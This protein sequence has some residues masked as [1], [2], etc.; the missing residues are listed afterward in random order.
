MQDPYLRT[1]AMPVQVEPQAERSKPAVL[2]EALSVLSMAIAVG[3]ALGVNLQWGV[4]VMLFAIWC[5]AMK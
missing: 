5:A 2:W 1:K 4:F 3:V